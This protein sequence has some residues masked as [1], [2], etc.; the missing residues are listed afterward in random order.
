MMAV[1][2]SINQNWKILR[3]FKSS[4]WEH[5]G[6]SVDGQKRQKVVDETLKVSPCSKRIAYAA[7]NTSNMMTHLHHPSI[8]EQDGNTKKQQHDILCIQAAP[9]SLSLTRPK[10]VQER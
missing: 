1:A 3:R 8:P 7:A 10:K 6:I 9:G 4:I 2:G 5:F